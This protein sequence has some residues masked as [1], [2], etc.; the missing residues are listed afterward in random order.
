MAS[1]RTRRVLQD[2]RP[3]DD[4]NNC[5]ECGAHNPQWVS[6][7][8]GIWICLECSGK[9]RGLGVHLSFVRSVT[10]DKWKDIEL[11]KMK[12]GGNKKAKLFLEKQ[13]DWDANLP[14][15]ERYNT[16]AAALYRD[17]I[18]TEAQGK[19][20][21]IET[22]SAKNYTPHIIPKNSSNNSLHSLNSTGN[23]SYQDSNSNSQFEEWDSL[24]SGYQSNIPSN[25]GSRYTGFGYSAPPP[26][27]SHSQ[28]VFDGAMASLSSGWSTFASGATKFVYKASEGVVKLGSAASQKVTEITETVNE[29]VKEG[30]L[31]EDLQTQV[32]TIGNK[33]VDVSKKGWQDLSVMFSQKATTLETAEGAPTEKSSL[34][35][36]SINKDSNRNKDIDKSNTPLLDETS[37]SP[38]K[39]SWSWHDE[40]NKSQQTSPVKT[41]KS[42]SAAEWNAEEW[43][44]KPNR[45]NKNS[46]GKQSSSINHSNKGK[47]I[48]QCQEGEKLLIDFGEES[49]SGNGE[50]EGNW[51]WEE[52]DWEDLET[53][54]KGYQRIGSKKD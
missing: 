15:Q 39:D 28:E 2:L 1:P 11:E 5:F 3:R 26:P 42:P 25:Q 53:S 46:K 30:S 34:L 49:K 27:R 52:D 13:S 48:K 45:A 31:I 18:A 36:G 22:S 7:T 8:Y 24:G 4:N 14:L 38:D 50:V 41:K 9:H 21:S 32:H 6:V 12:V 33:V 17:K 54:S 10:M 19:S 44:S 43:K 47:D 40:E 37:N 29:K 35:G 20:W 16:K 51:G 23:F